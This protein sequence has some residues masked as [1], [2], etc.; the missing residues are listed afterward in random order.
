M[1]EQFDNPNELEDSSEVSVIIRNKN[2]RKKRKHAAII[3]NTAITLVCV[4]LGIIISIQYKSLSA[5][6][7][8][9]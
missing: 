1:T 5:A 3:R 8:G 2:I 9:V 6:E 7:G 4:V